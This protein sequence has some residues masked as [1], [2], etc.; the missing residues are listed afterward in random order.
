MSR[1]TDSL[2][3][4][5]AG[6]TNLDAT[7][8]PTLQTATSAATAKAQRRHL[9]KVEARRFARLEQHSDALAL[10]DPLPQPGDSLHGCTSGTFTGWSLAAATID[11]LAEPVE[12]MTIA[13][14]GFN[15]PNLE[16]L[17]EATDA[18]KVR[19]VLLVVSDYFR[20]SDR[21]IFADCRKQLEDRGHRVA[22]CRSHAKLMLLRTATRSIVIETSA[23]LRS[24]MN[25]EQF[26]ISDDAALLDFHVEWLSNL[27]DS[28]KWPKPPA[29]PETEKNDRTGCPRMRDR[30]AP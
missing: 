20:S 13:T 9:R 2:Q 18:G 19:H 25:W 29:R 6:L 14:L 27:I 5:D 17:I 8:L 1:R 22:V 3:T 16:D 23:N 11:L 7:G 10:L 21:S 30:H 28:E 24:S 15:R 12:Q 26:T 4:I